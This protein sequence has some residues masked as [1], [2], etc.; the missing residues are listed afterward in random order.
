MFT[1]A[2]T[3]RITG[4]RTLGTEPSTGKSRPRRKLAVARSIAE[5]E[6]KP[7]M[8]ADG[9]MLFLMR[10]HTETDR[11]R[12]QIRPTRSSSPC[13]PRRAGRRAAPPAGARRLPRPSAADTLGRANLVRQAPAPLHGSVC[14]RYGRREHV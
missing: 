5:A 8:Y 3:G 11:S 13:A 6:S 7:A 12:V 9:F 1:A 10:F 4:T 14:P 2:A